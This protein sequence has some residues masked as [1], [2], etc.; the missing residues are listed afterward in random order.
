MLTLVIH[1]HGVGVSTQGVCGLRLRHWGVGLNGLR[2]SLGNVWPVM[3]IVF[4]LQVYT[5]CQNFKF[6]EIF[7]S[8]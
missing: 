6:S 4:F 7:M 3:V 5:S 1:G 8:F 2:G